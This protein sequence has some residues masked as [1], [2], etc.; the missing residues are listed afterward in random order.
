MCTLKGVEDGE[1]IVG[2]YEQRS[3]AEEGKSPGDAQQE[4]QAQNGESVYLCGAVVISFHRSLLKL[5]NLIHSYDEYAY[6][7]DENH[8]IITHIHPLLENYIRNP[9]PE[10]QK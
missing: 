3:M 5:D 7:E 4:E 8:S 2:G 6:G 1:D 9:A 10:N